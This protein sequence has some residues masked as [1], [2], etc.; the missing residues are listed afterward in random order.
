MKTAHLARDSLLK[1]LQLMQNTGRRTETNFSELTS[2]EFDS[3]QSKKVKVVLENVT[4][5][6]TV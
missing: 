3:V 2:E 5:Q 6:Q 4:K 1:G